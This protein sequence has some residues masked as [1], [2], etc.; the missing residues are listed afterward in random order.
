MRAMA[1]PSI[2][3]RPTA[4]DVPLHGAPGP[5]APPG[6]A[7]PAPVAV[8]ST[9]T[10]G[11]VQSAIDAVRGVQER[12]DGQGLTPVQVAT[13]APHL[14]AAFS[15]EPAQVVADLGR[16]RIYVGGAAYGPQRA[17]V[18]LGTDIYVDAAADVERMLSWPGRRWLVHE[19]GHTMQWR[20]HAGRDADAAGELAGMRGFLGSYLAGFPGAGARGSWAWLRD[21]VGDGD[22][23]GRRISLADALHDNHAMEREAEA[24]AR[25]FLAGVA[26]AGQGARERPAEST[27]S[28]PAA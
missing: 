15:I 9:R 21:R 13:I 17:A 28:V 2:A 6:W 3:C 5:V 27:A 11:M 8:A 18:T 25:A 16:V 19:L 1:L 23:D 12:G 20:R 24:S 22:G 26:A 10:P 7:P 14:A 4:V